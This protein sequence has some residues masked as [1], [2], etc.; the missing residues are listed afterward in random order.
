MPI[1]NKLAFPLHN[2]IR[3]KKRVRFSRMF[4]TTNRHTD[5]ILGTIITYSVHHDI[6]RL[7]LKN[8]HLLNLYQK[9]EYAYFQQ[10]SLPST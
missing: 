8:K 6:G 4:A 3:P 2:T 7:N 9:I 10:I 5:K 1:F